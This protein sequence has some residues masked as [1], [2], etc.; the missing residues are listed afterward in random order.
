MKHCQAESTK[1]LTEDM[2]TPQHFCIAHTDRSTVLLAVNSGTMNLFDPVNLMPTKDANVS[3][4]NQVYIFA[5]LLLHLV[6]YKR[7]KT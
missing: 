2:K 3:A 6:N 4:Q 5:M 1:N 7:Q